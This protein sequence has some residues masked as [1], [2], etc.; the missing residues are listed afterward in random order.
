MCGEVSTFHLPHGGV[1]VC[2]ESWPLSGKPKHTIQA[3]K[4][5][6]IINQQATSITSTITPTYSGTG[7]VDHHNRRQCGT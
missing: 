4:P 3:H 5:E 1:W 6:A 2:A 7:L